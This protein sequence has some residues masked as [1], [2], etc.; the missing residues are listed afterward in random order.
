MDMVGV[1]ADDHP[2][3]DMFILSL[4]RVLL[5]YRFHIGLPTFR[6]HGLDFAMCD[7]A[8]PR[9]YCL[10]CLS[11]M[12][13]VNVL[14]A[15]VVESFKDL[16]EPRPQVLAVTHVHLGGHVKQ[17]FRLLRLKGYNEEEARICTRLTST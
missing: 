14:N 4:T 5:E 1:Q 10:Y 9:V 2:A 11:R 3:C 8:D 15:G 12:V 17:V 6:E 7:F 13:K 16:R